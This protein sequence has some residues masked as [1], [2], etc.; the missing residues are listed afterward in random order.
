M[1]EIIVNK[2]SE[3]KE[4]LSSGDVV[5]AQTIYKA[6]KNGIKK[7]YKTVTIFNV[8]LVEDPLSVYK[9]KLERDQWVTALNECIVVFSKNDLFEDCIDIQ[10]LLKE[11]ETPIE[12]GNK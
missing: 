2:L 12:N 6:V 1:K 5:I 10:E 11:V 7:K 3:F 4:R 9:F 8:K